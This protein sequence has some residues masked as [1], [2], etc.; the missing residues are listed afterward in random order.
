MYAVNFVKI[1]FKS[2]SHTCI[3]KLYRRGASAGIQFTAPSRYIHYVALYIPEIWNHR[4]WS[5]LILSSFLCLLFQRRNLIDLFWCCWHPWFRLQVISGEMEKSLS[6][7]VQFSDGLRIDKESFV[8]HFLI[9]LANLSPSVFYTLI[10][11]SF[12]L[13]YFLPRL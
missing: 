6:I 5:H 4:K 10:N 11:T 12:M 9:H 8:L 7:S 2:L 3:T 13:C 1:H